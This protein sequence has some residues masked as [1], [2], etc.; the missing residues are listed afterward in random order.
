VRLIFSSKFFKKILFSLFVKNSKIF[1]AVSSQTS[2]KE[3]ISSLENGKSII[4][5]FDLIIFDN[6]L[7]PAFQIHGIFKDTKKLTIF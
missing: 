4:S 7:A 1:L 6:S 2:F 3:S 5:S